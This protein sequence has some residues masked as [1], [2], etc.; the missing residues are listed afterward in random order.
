MRRPWAAAAAVVV[1]LG[2]CAKDLVLPDLDASSTC[3]NGIVEQGEE[4]DLGMD[5]A[6]A[7]GCVGCMVTP[8]WSCPD[9][10]CFLLCGDGVVGDA[11]MCTARDTACDMT[12]YW[13]ARENDYTRDS[14]LGGIQ[15]SSAWSLFRFKQTGND[16][17]VVEELDCGVHVTGEATVDPT[18][19]AM[20]ANM[21]LNRM[22]GVAQDDGG[23]ARPARH[24]TST[25]VSGGC[26]VTLDRWYK[27]RGAVDSY[28]PADFSTKPVLS[29][30]P[31]LPS[32]PDGGDPGTSTFWPSGATDPDGDGVPGFAYQVKGLLNGVRNA[33]EREWQEY[34]T[35]SGAPV[36]AYAITMVI[37][38]GYDDQES[39]MRLTQCTDING[40]PVTC[41]PLLAA[42]ANVDPTL[43]GRIKLSFIGKTYGSARVSSVVA[44]VPRQNPD[45][46]LTTCHNVQLTLPHDTTPPVPIDA[47]LHD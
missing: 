38:D 30:L 32:L 43:P 7:A 28:L 6:A 15:M 34:A 26:L 17:V 47:G 11:G 46:D 8:G 23:V 12:G 19:G 27:L 14:I 35:P 45:L 2:G 22:D 42:G 41:S 25:A 1:A 9:N 37:P 39:V 40:K 33:A 36:P 16:F 10:T 20:R 18:P 4:C 13:A 24:G 3:G 29:S 31:P 21:Y 44:G 5:A